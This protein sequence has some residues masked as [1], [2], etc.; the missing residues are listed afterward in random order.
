MNSDQVFDA[1]EQ[2]AATPGKKDKEALVAAL[3]GDDLGTDVLVAC[4]D[5]FVTY[6]IA[7]RPKID[8][9]KKNTD[10]QF[11]AATWAGLKDL[12]ARR[13]TGNAAI[14]WLVDHMEDLSPKSEELLWRI[15][16][17]DMRA[18]FTE[19]TINRAKPGTI[20]VFDCMLAHPYKEHKHKL[21]FPLRAEPKI[22]GV[23]VLT[24]INLD[25]QEV[26]FFSRSGKEFT[27]FDHLKAPLIDA[28]AVYRGELMRKACD[29]YDKEGGPEGGE[30]GSGIDC[31]HMDACYAEFRADEACYLVLEAEVVS[32]GFNKTVG[33]VRRKD[34]QAID[35]KLCVFDLL[36]QDD[37][38]EPGPK[39]EVGEETY[40]QRRARLEEFVKCAPAGAPIVLLPSKVVNSEEEIHEHYEACRARGLE[41]LIVKDPKALYYRKRHH[42]WSKIKA[43][44][45]LDLK[46]IGAF[47]GEG[48]YAGML[49]GLIVDYKGVSVNVGGGFT[50][51]QRQDLWIGHLSDPIGASFG[52]IK[53]HLADPDP[54][55]GR[56]IEVQ[57][58]E[59]TPDGSL[60]HPRFVRFRDDKKEV[61]A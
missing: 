60:R 40:E 13:L 32:G 33:D 3:L 23:R 16:S 4:Y 38:N 34:A 21:A 30:D 20:T 39:D 17:K 11:T 6:G 22:D 18:G 9:A 57:Y 5:P 52:T 19:G 49:G 50:D 41:G 59:V 15:I 2:I 10:Y 47:E 27:T 28:A 36:F 58:H 31:G 42:A 35:A 12:A 51:E 24:F 48:K 25:D 54:V 43:E 26:R 56:L 1:I 7:K 44:E 8:P 45:T 53:E 55:V 29:L 14:D 46:V 61:S 37:F